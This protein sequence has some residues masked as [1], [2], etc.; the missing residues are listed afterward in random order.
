MKSLLLP[1][2]VFPKT[3]AVT[4][5]I[6]SPSGLTRNWFY[7]IVACLCYPGFFAPVLGAVVECQVT[8]N[9]VL[10]RPC[11]WLTKIY[12]LVN[13]VYTIVP[14]DTAVWAQTWEMQVQ[15]GYTCPGEWTI[16][17][18]LNANQAIYTADL[19]YFYLPT[20]YETFEVVFTQVT[21]L[22]L[23]P[24]TATVVYSVPRGF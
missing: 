5:R 6:Q 21:W 19:E 10:P 15:D 13:D 9:L 11:V 1:L 17:A 14:T 7:L 12:P 18:L 3:G 8:I 2:R 22:T 4:Y 24:Q 23:T 16:D 20:G